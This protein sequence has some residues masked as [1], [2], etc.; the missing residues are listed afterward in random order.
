MAKNFADKLVEAIKAKGS[1]ICVGLDPRLEKIPSFIR[2]KALSNDANSPLKA[3]AEAVLEFNKGIMDSISDLVPVVKPQIAFYENL[4]F[5]GLRVYEETMKYAKSKGLLTIADA[6]RNDIGETATAYAKAFLGENILFE[7]TENEII[8]PIYDADSITINPYLGWDSV[9]PFIDEARKYKKGVFILVKTS[10]KSSGDLQDL[11][12]KD[13]KTVYEI[14]GYMVDS[15]GA[16]DI[17]ESG[18]SFVGAVV[19]ATYPLQAEKLRQIMPNAMFLVPG[20]GAQGATAKDLRVCFDKDGL[21]AI[22]N[23]SRGIIYAYESLPG[24]GEKNYMEA[25][26]QAVKNMK[27]DLRRNI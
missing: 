16:D 10:N 18:Y 27:E 23:N 17:G 5:E 2:E 21:G 25:A 12:M 8:V 9:K 11:V 4:G 24:F 7:D 1:C 26:R 3:A 20:Y 22:V 14:I 15:Y 13:G 6:K 19:G